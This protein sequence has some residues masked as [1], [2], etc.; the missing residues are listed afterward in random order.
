MTTWMRGALWLVWLA[1]AALLW[2]VGAL[3]T[4]AAVAAGLL[5][6][7]VL[8]W[9]SAASRRKRSDLQYVEIGKEPVGLF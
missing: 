7:V 8:L 6:V 1:V 5:S 3:G 4:G 2:R 9:P